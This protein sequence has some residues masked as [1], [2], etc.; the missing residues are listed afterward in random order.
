MVCARGIEIKEIPRPVTNL[1][2]LMPG[3]ENAVSYIKE[4][5]RG[6]IGYKLQKIS[7]FIHLK[8]NH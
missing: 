6:L 4:D 3:T 1:G 7:R 8:N 2:R 5:W